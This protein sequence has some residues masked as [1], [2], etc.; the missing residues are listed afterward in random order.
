M[1]LDV[2]NVAGK[3]L[4]AMWQ[5]YRAASASLLEFAI[6]IG[7]NWTSENCILKSPFCVFADLSKL[8][9]PE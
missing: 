9:F 5:F 2:F 1:D 7:E 4:F 6:S 3:P 8:I